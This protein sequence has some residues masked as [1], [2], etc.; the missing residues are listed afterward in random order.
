MTAM[1][2]VGI[3][4][5][6]VAATAAVGGAAYWIYQRYKHKRDD[7]ERTK[8]EDRPA[9]FDDDGSDPVTP[10]ERRARGHYIPRTEIGADVMKKFEEAF[11]GGYAPP[12]DEVIDHLTQEDV[13]LFG[14]E[15]EPVP[16]Y[17][18]TREEVLTAK[19][20]TVERSVV[21]ARVIGPVVHAEHHGSHAGHGFRVGD[22]VE[23]PRGV[24]LLAARPKPT[25]L[26]GY[27]SQGKSA[28]TF[29]PSHKTKQT[30]EIHPGTPYDLVMP[31]ITEDIE[32]YVDRE[33]VKFE[34]VGTK[35]LHQQIVFSEDSM[36]GGLTL[37]A[38]DRD[39]KTGL[40]FVARWE[41]DIQ[42]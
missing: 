28:A 31:Y 24:I 35:G 12:K 9:D 37:R 21:R 19:V 4:A 10:E 33:L 1:R 32:W 22:M 26:E 13:V 14:V 36:R 25:E 8:A 29:Q 6:T 16:G 42:P 40:V 7:A 27:D 34:L 41:F 39:P 11:G 30:Y 23:V 38:L 2:T 5:A 17:P 20:R 15:S 18:E 3:V